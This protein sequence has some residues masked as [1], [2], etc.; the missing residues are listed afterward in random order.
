[1]EVWDGTKCLWIWSFKGMKNVETPSIK[2]D[3]ILT[4]Q[5]KF[6]DNLL[7]HF[8]NIYIN[9]SVCNILERY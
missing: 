3:L 2:M 7:R 1:M 4:Q 6:G 8:L 5:G 9:N